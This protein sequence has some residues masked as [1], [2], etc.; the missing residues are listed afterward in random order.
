MPAPIIDDKLWALIEPLFPSPKP[1]H[2]RYPGRLPVSDRAALNGIQ[3]VLKTGMRWNHLQT[4]LGFDSGATCWRRL[5]HWQQARVWD[6]LHA[7]LLDKLRE[8]GQLDLSCAAVDSSS[9]R[10]VGAGQKLA[11]PHG[12]RAT[13]LQA[14][15]PRRRERRSGQRDPD[16]R[17]PQRCH[18]TAAAGRR[19]PADS[20]HT[21]PTTA[22]TQ[23]H[24]CRPR[25][26][27][28]CASSPTSRARHP[29]GHR[30]APHR[31]RQRP[32]QMPLG[33]RHSWLDGFRRLRIRFERRSDIHEAFLKLACSLVCWNI[34]SRADQPF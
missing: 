29:A 14:P 2:K 32:G 28:G 6:K 9:V 26:R 30:Q 22:Q 34:F 3:F 1:R 12:S 33:R 11:E 4:R 8:S 10:A 21:R 19:H 18:P 31:T 7:L 15:R 20:R 16:R 24:L 25:L 17:E 27:F 5:H 23:G 13:G